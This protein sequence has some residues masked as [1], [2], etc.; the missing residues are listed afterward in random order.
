MNKIKIIL[1]FLL[2][3]TY[4]CAQF[5][6]VDPLKLPVN[7]KYKVTQIN[8]KN[9]LGQNIYGVAYIPNGK[10][11]QKYPVVIFSHGFG[12]SHIFHT[13]YGCTLAENGIACYSF[14]FTGGSKIS[15]SDGKTTEMSVLTEK[16]DLESVLST[17]KNWQFI[18]KS[19]IFLCGESQGGF[20]SALAGAD[21][22]KELRGMILLYPAFHIPDVMRKLYPGG[23]GI[24]DVTDSISPYMTLGRCYVEDAIKMDAYSITKNFNKKVLI[25]HGDS[26][27]MVPISYAERANKEYPKAELKVIKGADHGFI[28]SNYFNE[29]MGYFLQYMK[30]MLR[31]D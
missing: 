28:Q 15:K 27:H 22:V 14:D 4:V 26:D 19:N 30:E 29:A 13:K 31:R 1:S 7:E 25:I 6:F 23:Q 9:Q 17:V 2:F 12:S 18:D 16:R 24:K 21:H 3:T 10:K 20:V 8:C 11:K 5:E